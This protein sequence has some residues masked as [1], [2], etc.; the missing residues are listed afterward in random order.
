[1]PGSVDG[2]YLSGCNRVTK[3][4]RLVLPGGNGLPTGWSLFR[5][6]SAPDSLP[7]RGLVQLQV[8]E[9]TL[10]ISV[11]ALLV[12]VTAKKPV[13]FDFNQ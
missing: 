7:C 1:M 6:S 5:G 10:F 4:L 3:G 11:V 12:K 2:F 13:G 8:M 9:N